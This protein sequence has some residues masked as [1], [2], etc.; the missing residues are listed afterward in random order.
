MCMLLKKIISCGRTD[1]RK[2]HLPIF[3]IFKVFKALKLKQLKKI[4]HLNL[5]RIV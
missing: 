1:D 2:K 4:D 5:K 3:Y